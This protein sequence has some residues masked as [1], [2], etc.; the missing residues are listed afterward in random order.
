MRRAL[1][2]HDIYVVDKISGTWIQNFE[3]AVKGDAAV[4]ITRYNKKWLHIHSTCVQTVLIN[5]IHRHIYDEAVSAFESGFKILG[6]LF[7][8]REIFPT[9][10]E[11][12]LE[13]LPMSDSVGQVFRELP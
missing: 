1:R 2:A 11:A 12:A 7:T 4:R 10:I 13:Q 6:R 3:R 8:T 5:T 9:P